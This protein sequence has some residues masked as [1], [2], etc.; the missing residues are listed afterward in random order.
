M[1]NMD[2]IELL[3]WIKDKHP[4]V[5]VFLRSG[6]GDLGVVVEVVWPNMDDYLQKPQ[7]P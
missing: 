4:D 6:F 3:H 7:T 5:F 2:G 1:P